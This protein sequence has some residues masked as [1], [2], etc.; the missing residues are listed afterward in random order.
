MN[1][2]QTVCFSSVWHSGWQMS[3]VFCMFI[4]TILQTGGPYSTEGP[5]SPTLLNSHAFVSFREQLVPYLVQPVINCTEQWV[6]HS[7][8]SYLMQ[9]GMGRHVA[10]CDSPPKPRWRADLLAGRFPEP[11]H[12]MRGDSITFPQRDQMSQHRLWY[13][14]AEKKSGKKL[15]ELIS[16]LSNSWRAPGHAVSNLTTLPQSHWFY[17]PVGRG[18]SS[19]AFKCCFPSSAPLGGRIF[20]S[21]GLWCFGQAW[22]W[23]EFFATKCPF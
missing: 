3:W 21:K 23:L 17:I 11:P 9:F 20:Q 8:F 14:K 4:C 6:R 16:V 7:R 5:I 1:G 19:K 12:F 22:Q 13:C 18:K 10:L 15:W 2:C